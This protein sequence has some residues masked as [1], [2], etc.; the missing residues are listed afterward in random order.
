MAL[1]AN[2]FA[3]G[4]AGTTLSPSNTGQY[5]DD[6]FNIV[7]GTGAAGVVLRFKDA[8]TLARPTAEYVMELSTGS[9]LTVFPNTEWNSFGS[10]PELWM[11]FYVY[12]TAVSASVNDF[13]LSVF[14]N[15]AATT[16]VIA[17]YARTTVSPITLAIQN[18]NTSLITYPATPITA[19]VWHRIE[20]H[21]SLGAGSTS[22]TD[23]RYYSGDNVDTDTITDSVSQASQNYGATTLDIAGLGQWWTNQKSTPTT[24]FSNWEIS[25]TGW[26]GPA[27][28]RQGLGYPAGNLTN[29]VAIHM[30]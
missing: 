25:T 13:N 26:V 24:Y 20:M 27:P 17:L 23:L 2:N 4:P 11:R 22:Y 8:S 14:A 19:G 15:G 12:F 30:V 29:P 9:T 7:A 1:L 10:F 3:G 28:F 6:A 18:T 21:V 16:G 5:G